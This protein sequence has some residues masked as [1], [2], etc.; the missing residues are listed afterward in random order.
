MKQPK[1]NPEKERK[2]LPP[3]VL[4]DEIEKLSLDKCKKILNSTGLNYSDEEIES[5]RDFLYLLAAIAA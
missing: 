5:I 4:V 2:A 1:K 3:L